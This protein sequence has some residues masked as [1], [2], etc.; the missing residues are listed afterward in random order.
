MKEKSRVEE[1]QEF[2]RNCQIGNEIRTQESHDLSILQSLI[3][4]NENNVRLSE[5]HKECID[6]LIWQRLERLDVYEEIDDSDELEM[7]KRT[8]IKE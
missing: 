3:D 2:E 6:V 5:D 1:Q 7:I 4:F 8:A